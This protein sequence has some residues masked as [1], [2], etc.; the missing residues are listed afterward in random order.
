MLII[1]E[2]CQILEYIL[3]NVPQPDWETDPD[4]ANDWKFNDNY[5]RLILAKN[6]DPVNA[7]NLGQQKT[8]HNAWEYLMAHHQVVTSD[9][10]FSYQR[11][12]TNTI[13]DQSANIATHLNQLQLIY[14]KMNHANDPQFLVTESQFKAI[15]SNSLPPSYESFTR[16]YTTM[17]KAQLNAT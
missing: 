17:D 8:S 6:I 16:L 2:M 9:K 13:V 11:K 10:L 4:Q 15:I 7:L 5:A 14:I 1:L 12:L 3:G